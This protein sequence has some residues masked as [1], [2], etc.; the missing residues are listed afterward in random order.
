[1]VDNI[2]TDVDRLLLVSKMK[3]KFV[4]IFCEI[5]LFFIFETKSCLSTSVFI[6]S[7]FLKFFKQN[8]MYLA[9]KHVETG[10]NCSHEIP[11]FLKY[12]MP[13]KLCKKR[14]L[15]KKFSYV[16]KT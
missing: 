1:M 10:L 16:S 5:E 13:L 8:F 9:H 11:N 2:K 14:S 4:D 3:K 7:A 12:H 15:E 6:I